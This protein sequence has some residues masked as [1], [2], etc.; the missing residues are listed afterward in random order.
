[1]ALVE[2]VVGC[3]GHQRPQVPRHLAVGARLLQPGEEAVLHLRHQ[4][5]LLLADRLAQVVGLGGAEAGHPLGDLHQLLLVDAASVGRLGDRAQARVRVADRG[6]IALAAGVVG[7]EPHRA[8]P[9]Q[10]DQGDEVLELARA[11]LAQRLAHPLGLELEHAHRLPRGQHL[12]R[13]GVVQRQLLDV[14]LGPVRALDDVNGVLDHVEVAQAEEVHLQQPD[15]LDRPHRVLGHGLVRALAPGGAVSR[16]GAP[17]L[18]E[19]QRD[20]LLQR[21]VGDHHRGGVDRVVAD[22]PLEALARRR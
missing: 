13:L 18:G 12:V 22:D 5:A 3:R 9:V 10:G 21:P 17:V 14:E 19:L 8:G 11:D 2:A 1:M 7:D 16:A 20:D 15:L 6:R 4:V